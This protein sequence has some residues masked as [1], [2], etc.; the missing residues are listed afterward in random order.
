MTLFNLFALTSSPKR[1]IVRFA[2]SQDVQTDLTAYL[3]AQEASFN[4]A[5]EEEI[6]FDGKYKPD[7]GECLVIKN[8]DDIDSLSHAVS[9][10]LSVAE[11]TPDPDEFEIIRALFTGYV[12]DKGSIVIL[13]QNFDKRKIISARGLSIFHSSNVYKKVDGIGVTIDSKLSATIV[14][15]SLKFFSFYTARQIFDL[16]AYYMEATDNDIQEFSTIPAVRVESIDHLISISDSWIRRKLALV[17]QSGILEAVPVS[18][19]RA[20]ATEFG[21]DL[22]INGDG[23]NEAIVLPGNKAE[24]KKVLRFLDEDYYKS[25]LSAKSYVSNS[26]RPA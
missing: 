1:R 8:F 23:E 12:S 25:P 7:E 15:S 9:N 22:S 3:K 20:A 21:I 6:D 13:L 16:S 14:D 17:K 4:K 19:I 10:P 26:K 24:L 18:V 2:L 5:A 11:I